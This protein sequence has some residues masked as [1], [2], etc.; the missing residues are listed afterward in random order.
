VPSTTAQTTIG[1][2]AS[3]TCQ[4]PAEGGAASVTYNAYDQPALLA[5]TFDRFVADQGDP[6][7]TC[8]ASPRGV[9]AW[10]VGPT[11]SGHILCYTDPGGHPHL[12]WTYESGDGALTLATAERTDGDWQRLAAWWDE[13]RVLMT[14]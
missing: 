1:A 9:G 6:T 14:H 4:L 10:Q 13:Y 5:T 12:V 11:F 2:A 7:G 8:G 3:V